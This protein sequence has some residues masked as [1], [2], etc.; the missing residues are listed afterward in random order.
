MS[1]ESIIP[2][3]VIGAIN[4]RDST[5]F[6]PKGSITWQRN[7]CELNR[8]RS[9][10]T[11]TFSRDEKEWKYHGEKDEAYLEMARN[12]GRRN[13]KDRKGENRLYLPPRGENR[14]PFLSRH[15]FLLERA[16]RSDQRNWSADLDA[17]EVGTPTTKR[18]GPELER[19][20]SSFSFEFFYWL[21]YICMYCSL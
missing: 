4:Q 18:N 21:L 13:S 17:T 12:Y 8:T 3:G 14:Q 11:P 15:D 9:R 7:S 16:D 19:I 10:V 5:E 6:L 1:Q 20:L 2:S